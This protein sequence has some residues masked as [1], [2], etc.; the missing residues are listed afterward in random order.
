MKYN[1]PR[2]KIQRCS[3]F[4]FCRYRRAAGKISEEVKQKSKDIP[5]RQIIGLRNMVIHEYSGISLGR[6]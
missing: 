3:D 6:V 5:W 4:S 2:S 1:F